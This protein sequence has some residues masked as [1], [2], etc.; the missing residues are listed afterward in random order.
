MSGVEAELVLLTSGE[1]LGRV[2]TPGVRALL[3]ALGV[4]N[5]QGTPPQNT[6]TLHAPSDTENATH[7]AENAPRMTR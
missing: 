5:T 1:S 4:T 7:E 3:R 6:A 2:E